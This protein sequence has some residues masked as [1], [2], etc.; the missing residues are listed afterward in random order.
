MGVRN[1]EQAWPGR[2]E[3]LLN[4]TRRDVAAFHIHDAHCDG[5][6]CYDA[7]IEQHCGLPTADDYVRADA[8][9]TALANLGG[10][11]G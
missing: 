7:N 6:P 8:L 5:G 9:L 10:G 11:H 3:A 1:D 4:P 2:L